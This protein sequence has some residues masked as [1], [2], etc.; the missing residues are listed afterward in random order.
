MEKKKYYGGAMFPNKNKKGPSSPDLTGELELKPETLESLNALA[1]NG[2]P[3]ILR[4][5]AWLK[6]G[7]SGKFYSLSLEAKGE[8]KPRERERAVDDEIP[9]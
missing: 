9:F 2:D 6:E 4:G 8:Y 1:K 3:L 5:S 7:R